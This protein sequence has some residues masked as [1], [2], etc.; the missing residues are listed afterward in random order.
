MTASF[1]WH[2]YETT[3]TDPRRD[4]PAQ[5]AA[6]RTNAELEPVG[7]AVTLFC[8]P[9]P[10]I[11]PHP[12]AC[13]IT[14]ITPQ[15]MQ[16]EGLIEAEFAA[17]VHELM[18]T[19]Q[20]CTVGYNSIRFDDEFTRN[21]FYRNFHDPYEREYKA[22]NSRWDLI[23]LARMC[24]ALRPAGIEWPR[25]ADGSPSFRLEDL[26]R[27]NQIE[28]Q[29]AHDALSDVLATI[30]L[31]RLLRREQP[32]LFQ[33][34]FELRR[35]QRAFELL[36]VARMTPLV[37]VSSRYPASRGCLA[38]I[39]PIAMHPSQTNAVIVCDLDTDPSILLD[40]AADEIADRVFTPRVDLPDGIE[41]IPLKLIHANKSPALA[42]L[43]VLRDVDHARIGLDLPRAL[44]HAARL[45][46]M[47]GVADKVRQVFSLADGRAEPPDPELAIYAGFASDADKRLFRQVRGTPPTQLG[48]RRF[49]FADRR[50]DELLLRYRA[51]NWPATLDAR[52]AARWSEFR[53]RRLD[54][55]TDL[56]TLTRE[57][58]RQTIAALRGAPHTTPQQCALLDE[59]A[60]WELALD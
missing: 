24:Y 27:S 43:S 18:S 38:V 44:A 59:L 15:R 23:D 34:H 11:L 54:T 39:A 37:H 46:A 33:F 7:D 40:L 56:T 52:E 57:Q 30:G 3:G 31:A 19:P 6:L 25:H 32:R 9:A 16:R 60:Q 20:T 26:A 12:Q 17:R 1:L 36:D 35:K 2:D 10:D 50:Y 28:Q 42:P 51:R 41:R 45:R 14:G 13:L 47:G 48:Q 53:T 55:Q 21:L 22:G 8:Q 58:Y 4:R 5:F 29:R 49:S